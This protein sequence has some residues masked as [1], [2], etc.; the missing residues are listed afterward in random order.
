MIEV[1]EAMATD[2]ERAPQRERQRSAARRI[3]S[4]GSAT[5]L[6]TADTLAVRRSGPANHSQLGGPCDL[7]RP[8][9]PLEPEAVSVIEPLRPRVLR[10]DPQGHVPVARSRLNQVVSQSAALLMRHDVDRVELPG[11]WCVWITSGTCGS[12]P[13]D[14]PCLIEG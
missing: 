2:W 6:V 4:N 12:Q 1:A 14:Y 7:M 13:D 3:G 8:G 9:G 5:E 11:C 10:E